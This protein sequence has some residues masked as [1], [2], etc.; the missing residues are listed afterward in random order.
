MGKKHK[1]VFHR[2]PTYTPNQQITIDMKIVNYLLRNI[3]CVEYIQ[4]IEMENW[5]RWRYMIEY[6]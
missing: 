4:K 1:F 5:M 6:E 3:N 2:K